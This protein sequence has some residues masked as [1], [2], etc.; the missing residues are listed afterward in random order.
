MVEDNKSRLDENDE[1][2]CVKR[3]YV[4]GKLYPQ[5]RV[6]FKELLVS[7]P[8]PHGSDK[9]IVRL[10]DTS[11]PWGNPDMNLDFETGIPPIR[12]GWI[13]ARGDIE[14]VKSKQI[15]ETGASVTKNKPRFIYRAKAGRAVT[16]MY[17]ARQGIITPEMEFVAI[18]ETLGFEDLHLRIQQ[19]K[20][21]ESIYFTHPG[22]QWNKSDFAQITP[23]FVRQEIAAGRAIIPANINHPE[24]EPMIIGRHFLVKVNANLG[25]SQVASCI[26][27]EL[28]KMLIAI[29]FGADTVMDLSTGKNIRETRELIIRNSPVPVGT[30]PIYEAIERVGGDPVDLNWEIY[31][32]VLIEQ[33]EQGVDYFTIHAGVLK[34]FI[35]LV[36]G[37]VCGIVSRG[38]AIM[39][40]WCKAHNKENFLYTHF[41][42]ICEIL[43]SYDAAF[44]LGD[45]LRPGCLADANDAAQMAELE[46]LGELLSIAHRYD[47]QAMIEGPGH[48]PMQLIKENMD[49]QCELCNQAP[50][51]TLGPLVTDIGA[52]YDHISS[53]IGGA[54]IGWLGA[55]MLCYVTAKEHLGLPD[56]DDVREGVIAHKIAAHAANI[57][58]GHPAA[59]YRDNAMSRARFNF[60]WTDQ[61][62]LCFDPQTARKYREERIPKDYRPDGRFCSMCGPGFC[63]MRLSASLKQDQ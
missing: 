51:Y 8:G 61:Y 25:N 2:A 16:Q 22:S 55:S 59:Q 27:Q 23:E 49:K 38:G 60:Q 7:K 35:P 43:R 21:G 37:R 52:G 46:T 10:Y 5:V 58:R 9:E 57:A 31:R 44:S 53:A 28:E 34:D 50:F 13:E 14:E 39:A 12:Q 56:V 29:R 26:E 15:R 1:P 3:I 40:A 18:R 48:V 4:S 41:E 32:D 47:V 54:I 17:Y 19:A 6:P 30:V 11:G 33:C 45:G 36:S 24:V 42:E 63:S 62:N 20:K